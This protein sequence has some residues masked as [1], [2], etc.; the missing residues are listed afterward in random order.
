[1]DVDRGDLNVLGLKS[2][3]RTRSTAMFDVLV[4]SH[5]LLAQWKFG[6]SS[7]ESV[8]ESYTSTL[9]SQPDSYPELKSNT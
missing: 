8:G 9:S 6:Y 2:G 4:V 1:M 3:R 5:E 7:S